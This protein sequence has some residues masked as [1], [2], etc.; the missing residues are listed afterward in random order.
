MHRTIAGWLSFAGVLLPGGAAMA[1]L[2]S[3]GTQFWHQGSLGV[4]VQPEEDAE[5][6]RVLSAG[7]TMTSQPR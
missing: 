2:E 1:Q 4:E 5:F 7:Q 3:L 6:G